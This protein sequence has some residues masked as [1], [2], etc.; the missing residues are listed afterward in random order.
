MS[1]RLH[2][3]SV[4]Q[5]TP[6]QVIEAI[7]G[8]ATWQKAAV[9]YAALTEYGRL[10]HAQVPQEHATQ[11]L[12]QMILAIR[13]HVTFGPGVNIQQLASRGLAKQ[14]FASLDEVVRTVSAT[15]SDEPAGDEA[16]GGEGEE[17]PARRGPI[18]VRSRFTYRAC[19][20]AE[21]GPQ[22]CKFRLLGV[23][24]GQERKIVLTIRRG[25]PLNSQI[26]AL[27]GQEGIQIVPRGRL[28]SL[29]DAELRNV[30]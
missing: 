18:A 4:G 16:E 19:Y 13:E 7:S 30:W 6:A 2:L 15:L 11:V 22:H 26:A 8:T 10:T 27:E 25:R 3:T 21:R 17:A 14:L 28:H 1:E 12:R 9:Q 29:I 23:Q 20:M 24:D 5:E